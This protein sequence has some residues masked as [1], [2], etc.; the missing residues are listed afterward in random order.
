M[1]END[2]HH[3]SLHSFDEKPRTEDMNDERNAN[4]PGQ[5][6]FGGDFLNEGTLNI[7]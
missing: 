1:Q 3:I 5:T 4:P 7:D 2:K 6:S